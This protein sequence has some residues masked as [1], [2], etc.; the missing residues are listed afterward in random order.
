MPQAGC[1]SE[2][3][4][5]HDLRPKGTSSPLEQPDARHPPAHDRID[6][7]HFQD[8]TMLGTQGPAAPREND[9]L[10]TG[11]RGRD[12]ERF[13]GLYFCVQYGWCIIRHRVPDLASAA[14]NSL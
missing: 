8:F 3:W 1:E 10:A 14:S 4:L 11:D 2:M 6:R 7:L 12:R 5:L 13:L 9:L